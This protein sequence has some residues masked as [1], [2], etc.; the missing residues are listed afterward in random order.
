MR[1]VECGLKQQACII[2]EERSS[3]EA[4]QT[5][6]NRVESYAADAATAVPGTAHAAALSVWLTCCLCSHRNIIFFLLVLWF[7]VLQQYCGGP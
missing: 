3:P 5:E 6:T 1:G 2:H 7:F 4:G